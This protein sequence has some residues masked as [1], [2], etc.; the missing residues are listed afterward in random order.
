MEYDLKYTDH[1]K[2]RFK[3]RDFRMC[4]IRA[5]LKS[6]EIIEDPNDPNVVTFFKRFKKRNCY[7]VFDYVRNSLITCYSK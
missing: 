7:I 3:Q 2:R 5:T 4:E 1:F 6:G